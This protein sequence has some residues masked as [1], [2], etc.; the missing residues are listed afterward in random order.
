MIQIK[1]DKLQGL[2][3]RMLELTSRSTP[4][5]RRDWRAGTLELVDE[6]LAETLVPGTSESAQK[7]LLN[8]MRQAL[9][10][11]A[12]ITSVQKELDKT[13][14]GISP[15]HGSGSHN[16]FLAKYY[17][18]DIRETYLKNWADIFDSPSKAG[19]LDIEGTAK[20][21]VS[22]L[23]Y[24]GMP[25]PSAYKIIHQHK[26]STNVIE[27]SALLRELDKKLKDTARYY[28]F[29]VPVDRAP[30]FLHS[31]GQPCRWMTPKQ[32]KSWK[33][34]YAPAAE[35]IR[36]HGGFIL[37]VRG[38]DVNEAANEA[39]SSL[40]QL[41][42]KFRSGSDNQFSILRIMWSKENGNAFLTRKQAQ[43][44][45]LRAFQ[46]ANSLHCL[47]I[48]AR[49][50]NILAIIE[51][52][53]THDPHVAIVNGWVAIE[54]LLVDT[55]ESDRIG[56]A[57][58]A[59]VVAASYFRTEMTWLTSNYARAYEHIC[60]IASQIGRTEKASN[61]QDS[62]LKPSFRGRVSTT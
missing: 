53:Q 52:L 37:T 38:R 55:E 19:K 56:A 27:F 14:K 41:S 59:R 62:W 40:S 1:P 4:W 18:E 57:R 51:P 50:R 46:R 54:S 43:P 25:A 33:R 34:T 5:H 39:R 32:L 6:A 36:H 42:F 29:A 48:G 22:H 47:D 11:D 12:G 23:L 58:M 61:E 13:V 2:V 3:P 9:G 17:A 15:T 44:L 45:K 31:T 20:R 26:E 7:E 35:Q 8:H 10:S 16:V 30:S 49:T 24:C 28:S 21:I 60:P